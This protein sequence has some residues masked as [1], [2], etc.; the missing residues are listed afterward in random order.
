MEQ[1]PTHLAAIGILTQRPSGALERD[2]WAAYER[3]ASRRVLL[4]QCVFEDETRERGPAIVVLQR[5][6]YAP[7]AQ[8]QCVAKILQWLRHAVDER[9]GRFVG[10]FDSDTWMHPQRLAAH[11][12]RVQQ[13]VPRGADVWGGFWEHW[14]RAAWDQPGPPK[15]LGG[16]GFSY[17]PLGP[18]TAHKE[19]DPAM[20]ARSRAERRRFSFGMTQGGWTYFSAAAAA[21]L[22]QHVLRRGAATFGFAVA[23][24]GARLPP[25]RP[26]V[27]SMVTDV[28]IGWL[29]AQ[30]FDGVAL[31]AVSAHH[32]L[33]TFTYPVRLLLPRCLASHRSEQPAV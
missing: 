22:V 32:L 30:A 1:H 17:S 31:H 21:R 25:T 13:A 19:T 29:G 23:G 3:H 20:R 4:R 7:W 14:E 18:V 5:P 16:V 24:D 9:L 8:L 27:C 6:S 11:L 10:W 2:M 28:G 33:E 26:G 12:S 15:S